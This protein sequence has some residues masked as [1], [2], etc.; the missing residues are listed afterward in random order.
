MPMHYPFYYLT[1]SMF[2]QTG[3]SEGLSFLHLLLCMQ[4]PAIECKFHHFWEIKLGYLWKYHVCRS[5]ASIYGAMHVTSRG[6]VLTG[7][8]CWGKFWI[9]FCGTGSVAR[10]L[11][12]CKGKRNSLTVDCWFCSVT[13][14][15]SKGDPITMVEMSELWRLVMW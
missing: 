14:H 10:R 5:R 12:A 4:M 7:T 11:T 2:S 9:V 1:K 15:R 8:A 13:S 3:C 6:N